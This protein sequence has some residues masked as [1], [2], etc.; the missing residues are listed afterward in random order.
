MPTAGTPAIPAAPPAVAFFYGANP[1]LD[2]LAAFDI[3]DFDKVFAV[4]VR[5]A[6]L[7]SAEAVRIMMGQPDR[8]KIVFQGASAELLAAPEKM[9]ALLS[10]AGREAR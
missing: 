10:V 7:G 3:A 1:P 6:F 8:G 4:N 5:S 2:E 9:A